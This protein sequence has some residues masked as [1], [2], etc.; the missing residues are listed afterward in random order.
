GGRVAAGA[1]GGAAARLAVGRGG[2]CGGGGADDRPARG[3]SAGVVGD[4]SGLR[5]PAEHAAPQSPMTAAHVPAVTAGTWAVVIG[6]CGA[7]CSAG[8]RRP[9]PSPTTP[10]LRPRAGRS[11]APPPPHPPPRPTANRAAAP[12][13]APAAT[14]P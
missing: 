3:R 14:R 4:G 1:G 6:L 10:A 12:P 13:P 9:E 11:S 2:G 8:T 5:V 7:A